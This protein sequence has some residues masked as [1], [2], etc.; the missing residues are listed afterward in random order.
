MW[1][2]FY[3]P[4]GHLGPDRTL[5][6]RAV[7]DTVLGIVRHHI[8]DVP[9]L[10]I[11]GQVIPETHAEDPGATEGVIVLIFPLNK[12]NADKFHDVSYKNGVCPKRVETNKASGR[13]P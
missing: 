6:R 3:S 13:Q 4:L 12:I 2:G 5:T 9:L 7:E 11:M 8:V 1:I 10:D